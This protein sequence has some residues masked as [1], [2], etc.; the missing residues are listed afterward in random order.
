VSLNA[1][2]ERATSEERNVADWTDATQ[3]RDGAGVVTSSLER[4]ES[5]GSEEAPPARVD[6]AKETNTSKHAVTARRPVAPPRKDVSRSGVP[7]TLNF[8]A[9]MS[10]V[11]A[12]SIGPAQCGPEAVGLVPAAVTFA[13]SGQAV[14][15]VIEDGPLRGT[16]TGSCVALR[17]R[18]ARIAPFEGSPATVR[19]TVMMR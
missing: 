9:A 15:A 7:T 8:D 13:P 5:T 3:P 14:R 19:T 16:T 2:L 1:P 18:S 11:A 17:L 4:L 10:A 12:M 6:A